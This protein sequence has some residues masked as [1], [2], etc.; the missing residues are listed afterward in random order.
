[1]H[2]LNIIT[3]NY[4]T[5]K[6]INLLIYLFQQEK[7]VKIN[8][9]TIDNSCDLKID[10]FNKTE[11]FNYKVV[12]NNTK[13]SNVLDSHRGGLDFGLKNLDFN[14]EF[15]LFI[16]PDLIF[17]KDALKKCLNYMKSK[18]LDC[19]GVHKFYQWHKIYDDIKLPYI[20]FTF[21]KT[22][23]LKNFKFKYNDILRKYFKISRRIDTGDNIYKLVKKHNLKYELID[24]FTKKDQKENY[25]FKNLST[26]DWIDNNLKIII[27]HYRGGSEDRNKMTHKKDFKAKTNFFIKNARDFIY[28]EDSFLKRINLGGGRK[29][30]KNL[31]NVDILKEDSIDIVHDLNNSPY[32]FS[33][34]SVAYC[35]MDNILEHLDKPINVLKELHRIIIKDGIVEIYVPYYKYEGAFWDPQ[36]KN[37]F[38]EKY[39]D[40]FSKKHLLNYEV[41]N[42]NFDILEK[43][44]YIRKK[45]NIINNPKLFF[46][47]IIPFKSFF[48]I[49]LW[50]MYDTL[51]VK[52][53]VVK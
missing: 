24:K 11:N 2:K 27:S 29:A 6:F 41:D 50:N 17:T 7:D 53:K 33:D 25:I 3:V 20:W 40:Y 45:G 44:I 15:T 18:D 30:L 46:R 12:K 10:E 37:Y 14:Y 31:L 51:Y 39:F 1:M 23:Y 4:Q 42:I 49:F 47:K 8:F 34:N 32:P 22:N 5:D 36:H 48:N 52:L 43:K 35:L 16:D 38:H 26:D 9:I 21:I 13:Y 19:F 28:K